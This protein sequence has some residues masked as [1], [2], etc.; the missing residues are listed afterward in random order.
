MTTLLNALILL[1]PLPLLAAAAEADAR[2]TARA[3]ARR[4]RE[5]Q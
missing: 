5:D 3:A 1:A 4:N 2:R